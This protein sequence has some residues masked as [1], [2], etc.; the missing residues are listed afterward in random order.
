MRPELARNLIALSATMA[1]DRR[2][3]AMGVV[4]L[5]AGIAEV[6]RP[7]WWRWSVW[8]AAAM[9]CARIEHSQ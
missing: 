7:P 4:V 6:K 3:R 5:Y 1:P 8:L 2:D 9:A